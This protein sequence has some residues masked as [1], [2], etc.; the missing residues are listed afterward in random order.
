MEILIDVLKHSIMI[1]A[2]VLVM[3]LLLEYLTIKT[4]DSWGR[5][6]RASGW[7]QIILAAFLGI[8]PGCLGTFAAVSL[9][10]H[11]LLNFA[12]LV[13]VMI[14][15]S[16]DEAFVMFSM[17]PATALKLMLIIFIIAIVTGLILNYLLK[18]KTFSKKHE[19]RKDFHQNNPQCTCFDEKK[20]FFQLK[21]ITFQ[22]AMLIA[23][24]V[25]FIIF[26]IS[27]E[28]GPP[29]WGWERIT[30]L[31]IAVIEL[32]IVT[33]VPDHFLD[34]HLWQ[35]TIKEHLPRIFLWTFGAFIL[36]HLMEDYLTVNE[37]IA[38]NLLYILLIAL[39]VGLIPESG[40]H[41]V[42]ITLFYTGVIPFTILLANSIVQ[43]GH[44]AIPL[45]AESKWSFLLMK[46]VNL[47]VGLLVGLS[48][49]Y[50]F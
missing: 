40:P 39:L 20:F 35:H 19:I 15:T 41:I 18:D 43:D 3:M 28:I 11:R 4:K 9:Y 6:L 32:F 23:G 12:A 21:N 1:S 24:G 27:G 37:W 47:L 50:L 36:I 49:L 29:D 42:F 26:L 17:I 14:A 13:T 45:L 31:L 2:F 7:K 44:G 25:F 16:G 33:T 34:E 38:D 22:R 46:L 10:T 8:L 5:E 30:F 48:G